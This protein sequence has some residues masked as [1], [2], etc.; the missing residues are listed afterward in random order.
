MSCDTKNDQLK[1][2]CVRYNFPMRAQAMILQTIKQF[3]THGNIKLKGCQ[4]LEHL[5][6]LN[7][8]CCSNVLDG[9]GISAVLSPLK[10][11]PDHIGVQATACRCLA[12][13]SMYGVENR[14]RL[15][16]EG[17]GKALA[18]V[19]ISM[20]IGILSSAIEQVGV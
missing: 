17:G 4:V 2:I 16:Q 14:W 20:C 6:C 1:T 13:I 8:E 11:F 12:N 9:K 15:I 18:D 5:T 3:F 19:Q 10:A 7:A